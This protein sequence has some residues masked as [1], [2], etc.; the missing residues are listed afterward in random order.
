MNVGE[1]I[2]GT[3]EYNIYIYEETTNCYR[4]YIGDTFLGRIMWMQKTNCYGFLPARS[5]CYAPSFCRQIN[6]DL[7]TLTKEQTKGYHGYQER[8]P[9]ERIEI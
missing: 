8:L 1:Q 9:D 3:Y 2:N 4:Y 7:I 5:W 6:D